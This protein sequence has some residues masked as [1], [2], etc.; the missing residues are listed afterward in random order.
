MKFTCRQ[1]RVQSLREEQ[2]FKFLCAMNQM[3]DL[4]QEISFLSFSILLCKKNIG[5]ITQTQSCPCEHDMKKE[6]SSL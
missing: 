4:K 6:E 1:S 2:E 5:M 3:H